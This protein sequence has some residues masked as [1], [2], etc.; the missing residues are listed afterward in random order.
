MRF[1]D[2]L[3]KRKEERDK[4]LKNLDYYLQIIKDFFKKKFGEETKIYIFGSFLTSNFGPNSDIDILVVKKGEALN[5]KEETEI[6]LEIIKL[7]GF[8]NPFEFHI[9]SQEM[10]DEWYSHFIKEK[11]EI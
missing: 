6:L 3:L 4:Y 10:Y 7:I 2:L 1:F 9:V 11:K 5:S 8:V